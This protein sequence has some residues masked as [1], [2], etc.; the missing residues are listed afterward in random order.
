MNSAAV[1]T[2]PVLT[3]AIF[4]G[5]KSSRMGTPKAGVRL[6]SGLTMVEHVFL[7]L[8]QVCARVVF[9]GHAEGVA[10]ALLERGIHLKDE[11]PE[12]GPLGALDA[13]LSSGIAGSY[14][15]TPCDL[16]R[17]TPD[18]Y[19][20]L[21][22]ER[23]GSPLLLRHPGGVEPLVG[24]YHAPL[25]DKVR[26]QMAQR[27]LAVRDLLKECQPGYIDVPPALRDTLSNANT[28]RDVACL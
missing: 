23:P 10:P 12:L 1:L 18:L 27:R 19:R 24:V 22:T 25:L 14:L 26:R 17:A 9:V 3:G 21:I 20:L 7:A 28:P 11:I 5:G 16:C 4:C 15:V 6:S 8:S 2:K 13:L